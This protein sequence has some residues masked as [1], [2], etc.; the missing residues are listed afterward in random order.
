LF[1]RKGNENISGSP[2]VMQEDDGQ[3]TDCADGKH[4]TCSLCLDKGADYEYSFESFE[5]NDS[6][7]IAL[8]ATGPLVGP[9]VY[10]RDNVVLSNS[11]FYMNLTGRFLFELHLSDD[12]SV[13]IKILSPSGDVIKTLA[14]GT[15]PSG[16][17]II[18]WDGRNESGKKAGSGIYFI[19]TKTDTLKDMKK[20]AVLK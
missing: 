12:S 13:D 17:S 14:E 9:A 6:S 5:V 15:M 7:T 19:Q 2:F 18:A 3:D 10:T 20:I 8:S 16:R 4:Y 1:V 11:V